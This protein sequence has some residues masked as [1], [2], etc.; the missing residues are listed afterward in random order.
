ME[1]TCIRYLMIDNYNAYGYALN[2]FESFVR[3]FQKDVNTLGVTFVSEGGSM[4][5]WINSLLK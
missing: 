1:R 5:A 3:A 4:S 2:N